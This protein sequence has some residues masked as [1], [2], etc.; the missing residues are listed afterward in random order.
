MK[1]LFAILLILACLLSF[2]IPNQ[3]A[4]LAQEKGQTVNCAL[5][6]ERIGGQ[7]YSYATGAEGGST[8]AVS[9]NE[10]VDLSW[11]E[12]SVSNL[13]PTFND[14]SKIVR[15]VI[16]D[17]FTTNTP[18]GMTHGAEVSAVANQLLAKLVSNNILPPGRVRLEQVDI[19]P[20][21]TSD[22]ILQ[23]IDNQLFKNKEAPQGPQVS[24]VLNLS[25]VLIPC[26]DS[27]KKEL[28]AQLQ[29]YAE[30]GD[31]GDKTLTNIFGGEDKA[32]KALTDPGVGLDVLRAR[33]K[34]LSNSGE[35]AEVVSVA[36]AGNF[37]EKLDAFSPG[38]W[39]EVISVGGSK[40][41]DLT[42]GWEFFNRGEMLTPGAWYPITTNR[43]I[44]GTS[45]AAPGASVFLAAYLAA[46][47]TVCKM[48]LNA[49][50]NRPF[51]NLWLAQV[52][53]DPGL[54]N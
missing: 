30:Q 23:Q 51:D 4:V 38:N 5:P 2:G 9:I 24:L 11:V 13:S 29:K 39:P 18:S 37:G 1:T 3:G 54:C 52:E 33:I 15:L 43:F 36:A 45:F 40:F 49:L 16:V 26:S 42:K 35:F 48:H 31:K 28:P 25:F 27:V 6:A 12:N 53:S 50:A 41:D 10:Q 34:D 17:D 20:A 32:V 8:S 19:G 44:A 14:P 7:A 47:S 46:D 21:Y 22:F